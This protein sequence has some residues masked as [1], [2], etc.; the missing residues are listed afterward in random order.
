MF[1][2][3][4]QRR[5]NGKESFNRSWAEYKLGY[6]LPHEDHW[7]GKERAYLILR[8]RIDLHHIMY[9]YFYSTNISSM[10]T[11]HEML[12]FYMQNRNI[13]NKTQFLLGIGRRTF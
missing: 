7:I 5:I 13:L 12:T 2:Q 9:T 3:A 1:L 8:K 10:R 11:H 6:G 4:I